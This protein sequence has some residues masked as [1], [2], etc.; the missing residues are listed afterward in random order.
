MPYKDKAKQ[1][2]YQTRRIRARR[3]A[4]FAIHGPCAHCGNASNLEVDHIDPSQKVSHRIWTWTPARL[5]AELVK[6]QVLCRNCNENKNAVLKTV[7]Y[8][9]GTR[10]GYDNRGCRCASCTAAN[11]E[12]HRNY[13]ASK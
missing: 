12:H 1:N 4:W 5:N 13:R 2:A 10:A 7:F 11:T 3:D 8:M 9:H 6:C